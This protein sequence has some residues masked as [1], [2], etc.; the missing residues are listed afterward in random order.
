MSLIGA[1]VPPRNNQMRVLCT[2]L[3][4][5]PIDLFPAIE[6]ICGGDIL[7]TFSVDPSSANTESI[8]NFAPLFVIANEAPNPVI[9]LTLP[10]SKVFPIFAAILTHRVLM[11]QV[12]WLSTDYNLFFT[13]PVSGLLPEIHVLVELFTNSVSG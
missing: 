12:S 6:L 5:S 13:E 2:P 3:A 8:D 9:N 7:I 4:V 11:F 1:P 10:G